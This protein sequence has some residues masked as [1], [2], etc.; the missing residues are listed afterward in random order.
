MQGA[1]AVQQSEGCIQVCQC[2]RA[3]L[4]VACSTMCE[5]SLCAKCCHAVKQCFQSC[6]GMGAEWDRPSLPCIQIV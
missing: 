5:S 2:C 3:L 4:A 6:C 1:G